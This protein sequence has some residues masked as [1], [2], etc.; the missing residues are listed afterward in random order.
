MSQDI[1]GFGLRVVISASTTFPSGFTVT[2]FADDTDPLDIAS[3]QISDTA[4]SL[5]G[6]LVNWS[7]ANPIPM[8]VT[9]IPQSDSDLNLTVLAEANRV[10]RGKSSNRDIITA[11]VVYPDGRTVNLFSGKLTNAPLGTGVASAGRMKS[12]TFNFMFEGRTTN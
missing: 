1:S 3:Q 2:E 5:N 4:M 7:T 12:K 10:S 8:N 6:D 11:S 9:V